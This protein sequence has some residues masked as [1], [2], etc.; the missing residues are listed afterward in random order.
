VTKRTEAEAARRTAESHWAE[1]MEAYERGSGDYYMQCVK[2]AG[3][4]EVRARRLEALARK[5][6]EAANA[7]TYNCGCTAAGDNVASYCPVHGDGAKE[8]KS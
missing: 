5:E 4:L 7:V 6:K 3:Q 1:A 8:P 2:K